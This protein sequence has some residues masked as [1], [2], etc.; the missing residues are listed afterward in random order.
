MKLDYAKCKM[1]F[2]CIWYGLELWFLKI[3]DLKLFP[4]NLLF[5]ELKNYYL[6][7]G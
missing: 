2:Y 4:Y 5:K 3:H 7:E 6:K 1:C